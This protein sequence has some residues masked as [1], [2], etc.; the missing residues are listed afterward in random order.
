MRV[1]VSIKSTPGGGNASQAARYIAYRDRDEER[2][3]TEPRPLFSAKENTLSF[4]QAERVLTKDRTP[5]KDEVAHL[6]VSLKADDF[7]ALGRDETTRQ[8]AL[9]D[10]TREAIAEIAQELDAEDLRWVAGVHRNT[11]HPHLHLLIHKDYVTRTTGQPRRFARLPES[12]LPSRSQEENGAEKIQPGSF[13]HAFASALDRAQERARQQPQQREE[14]GQT[15]RALPSTEGQKNTGDK[16]DSATE[17]LLAAAQRNPSLAGRE[18]I[19][20]LILRGAEPEPN[21][22]SSARDLRTA[23]RTASLSDSDYRT[24]Y[25]QA[26]WLGQ[27]SQ[28]LRDLYEHGASLNGDVLTLPAEEHELPTAHEQPF[29]TSLPYAVARIGNA[30][31]AADFH[32][33]AKSIAGET[34][35]V[36]TEIEVFRHYYTQL[37]AADSNTARA[38]TTEKVLTEMRPLAEAMKVLETR[39]SLEA[40]EQDIAEERSENSRTELENIRSY[41][42]AAR[43]V[44]LR[45]EALRFPAGLSFAAQEKLVAQSLP[46]LDRLLESG[47]EKRAL[48]A[49]I[50]GATY[51]PE[52]SEEERA[53]RFKVSEFL[54]AYLEERMRDPETRALNSSAAFRSA[55]QQLNATTSS[56]ELNRFAETFLRDNLARGEALRLHKSD[57]AQHPQPEV[58]PLKARER[59]LLFY[60]RA[61][62]HHTAE[63]RELRYAWGLSREA[64]ASRVRDLHEGRLQPSSTLEKMLTELETRQSLPALKHY[65]AS[66]LNEKMDNPGKLDLQSLYERLP[67]HERTYLLERIAAKKEAYQRPEPPLRETKDEAKRATATPRSQG[68]LPRESQAYREYMAG[69]G[70]IEHRLVNEAVQRRQAATR[71]I[72]VSKEEYQLSITEARSLLPA[73]TQIKLRQQ[74]RNQAWEQLATP[75]VFTAEPKAQ[76]LSNTI[77]HLQENSQQRA[78]LAHQVLEEFV[79]EKISASANKEKINHAALTKLTPNDAQRWQALQDYAIRTREELYRGFESL[80]VIRRDIEQTRTVKETLVERRENQIEVDR[81]PENAFP[82]TTKV[83]EISLRNDGVIPPERN[84]TERSAVV[85]PERFTWVVESDQQWHFDRLPAP[86]ELPRREATN[87]PAREDLDHEFSY[88]R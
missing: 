78:R 31:Q 70:A 81:K 53:E 82:A 30:K 2:E 37:K 15:A 27:Q 63:M 10:V 35:D 19:T 22:R 60:G 77:A 69:M 79:Q 6:A 83:P 73:E 32:A 9:K 61:P 86:Q 43:T 26:D 48:I 5:T 8:Q 41:N 66:L 3:G 29:I 49:A 36:R 24:P 33:L 51:K 54:K 47:K 50:D 12:A 1:V 4:W 39:E 74:A 67:P 87:T 46:T 21:E 71:G 55:H 72:L 17:R 64:R 18:L 88:E 34:A 65:Q 76:E 16:S 44:H 42:T 57:P 14:V 84:S 59:N 45:D 68:D 58:M 38:E 25:E 13:S 62:E 40:Q 75:E 85:E 52:L 23:F 56:E 7:H 20:A 80:D 28:T 11:E